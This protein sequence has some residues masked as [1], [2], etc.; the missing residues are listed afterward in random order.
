MTYILGW[1]LESA[2]YLAADTAL[3]SS[4]R[5]DDTYTSFGEL[6]ISEPNRSV[7]EG[8]L[9]IFNL[10]RAA[11]AIS[12]N[13]ALA[14]SVVETFKN[15]LPLTDNPRSALERA[16]ASNGPFDS[17]RPISILVAFPDSPAPGLLSFNSDNQE[18]IEHENGSLVQFGSITQRYR[19]MSHQ[20]INNLV[21]FAREP[22]RFLA[23]I[24]AFLQSYGVHHVLLEDNVGGAF[25]GLFV[26][27]GSIEWQKDILFCVHRGSD[28]NVDMVSSIMRDHVLVVRSTFTNSCRYLADSLSCGLFEDWRCR[29]WDPAFDFTSLGRFDFVVLLNN[30]SWIVTVVELLKH[31]A[32]E[33]I[34]VEPVPGR[35]PQEAFRLNFSFSPLLTQAMTEAVPDRHDGSIPFK[36]NWFPYQPG[37]DDD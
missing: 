1:K 22:H 2:V 19:S 17:A 16:V 25:C 24:L 30:R 31:Q 33:H 32:G 21:L 10:E 12:G 9:K 8:C 29:W 3:T 4:R 35:G 14:R 18:I 26:G 7:H 6:H 11:I 34:R 36:F 5:T 20:M 15:A 23:T 13:V 27:E 37:P 28:P